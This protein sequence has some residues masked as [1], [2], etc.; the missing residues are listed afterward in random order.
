[1]SVSRD[2]IF[3]RPK[4]NHILFH[5]TRVDLVDNSLKSATDE[6]FE[7]TLINF[8]ANSMDMA[9]TKWYTFCMFFQKP[10]K[11][12]LWYVCKPPPV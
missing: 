2:G 4:Q 8:K 1:M 10:Q 11:I 5:K 9:N 6:N 3:F 12:T 7:F